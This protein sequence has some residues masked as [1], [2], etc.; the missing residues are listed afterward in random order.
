[1]RVCVR[2]RTGGQGEIDGEGIGRG[3]RED[4]APLLSGGTVWER[5]EIRS[6]LGLSIG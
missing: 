2:R 6:G 5:G 3:D 1:M 4:G